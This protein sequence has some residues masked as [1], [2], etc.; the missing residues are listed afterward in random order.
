MKSHRSHAALESFSSRGSMEA[1]SPQRPADVRESRYAWG[2]GGR[3]QQQ[4]TTSE[5]GIES[6]EWT[7][8]AAPSSTNSGG[9]CTN[10]SCMKC[11]VCGWV[12]CVCERQA[13]AGATQTLKAAPPRCE[14]CPSHLHDCVPQFLAGALPHHMPH[15][16]PPPLQCVLTSYK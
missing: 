5:W 14:K 11:T 6:V 15:C 4:P 16:P 9:G 12:E 1:A 8:I 7:S 3:Q 13:C 10:L 2:G